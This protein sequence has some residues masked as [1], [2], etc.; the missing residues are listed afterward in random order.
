M[1]DHIFPIFMGTACGLLV[2]MLFQGQRGE[3]PMR[4][5][6]IIKGHAEWVSD[7]NGR[8]QFK[9]KECK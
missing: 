9:W 4:E 8:P 3:N 6:A 2:A 1:K 7:T 5:E